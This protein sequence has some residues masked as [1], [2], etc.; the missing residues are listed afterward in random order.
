MEAVSPNPDSGQGSAP[1]DPSLRLDT[2][3]FRPDGGCP[4]LGYA[5]ALG[6]AL[7]GAVGMGYA[8]SFLRQWV[9]IIILFPLLMGLG[10]GFLGSVGTEV[11]KVRNPFL[12][13]LAGLFAGAAAPVAMHYFDYE[14][15]LER[16][17]EQNAAR[18]LEVKAEKNGNVRLVRGK[19]FDKNTSFLG[20]L[21]FMAEKGVN[22]HLRRAKF[23]LGY[24]GS[25]AY[26]GMELLLAGGFALYLM[27]STAGGPFCVRCRTWKT[28]RELGT[29][30]LDADTA[31][32]VFTEGEVVRLADPAFHR[33]DGQIKVKVSACP[34]CGPDAPVEVRLD[35]VFK[36]PKGEEKTKELAHQTYPGE[37]MPVLESL[38]A[39]DQSGGAEPP[40]AA[41]AG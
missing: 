33:G 38:F 23:N 34:H 26:W 3:P 32:R 24:Y 14:R 11:G 40:A 39:A 10:V 25:Y 36:N 4:P 1:L 28:E 29:L 27:A 8:A 13:G 2:A 21:D 15:L 41:P 35:H 31:A 16:A 5:L 7:A 17:R 6:L 30:T 18:Q 20:Y 22:I 19:A 9:Y 12:A 37:A